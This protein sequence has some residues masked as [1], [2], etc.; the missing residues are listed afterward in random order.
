MPMIRAFVTQ[1]T[2]TWQLM[3]DPRV[4]LWTKIIPIF[5]LLYIVS[6]FDFMPDVIPGLGQL[7][8]IG[9]LLISMRLMES[10]SPEMVVTEYRRRLNRN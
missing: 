8:D 10:V 2:L 6:P 4:P 7:D 3:R 1:L 5:A 9:I